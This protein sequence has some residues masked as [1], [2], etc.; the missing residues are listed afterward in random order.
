MPSTPDASRGVAGRLVALAGM[1]RQHGVPVGTSGVVD[2]ADVARTLGLADRERLRAGLASALLSRAADRPVFDQLFDVYFPRT[3]GDLTLTWAPDPSIGPRERARAVREELAV[4]LAENDA[5]ALDRLAARALDELGLLE[6]AATLG[7]WSAQQTLDILTPQ[8]AIVPALALARGRAGARSGPHGTGQGSGGTSPARF[9]DRVDRDEV[10]A[11]VAAFRRRVESESRRRN[12]EARGT[13]RIGRYA[14]RAPLDQ[15]DILLTGAA[16]VAEL[17]AVVGPLSRRL[18]TRLS[19][20]QR[21]AT[22]GQ[23]DIRR[24]LRAAMSTGGVPMRP[25]YVHR[26]R[27]RADL[28]VMSD[29]SSS[30]L[31]FS[32]F[33][34]LLMQALAG[35]FRRMRVIGFVNVCDEITDLVAGAAPGDDVRTEIARTARM[36]RFHGNSDYGTAFADVTE[37]YLEMLSPRST[38]L[39]LGDARSNGTDPGLDELR[40]IRDHA[41]HVAWL[42]P[43]PVERWGSGD[44]EAIRYAEV[45]DMHECRTIDQLR[46]FVSRQMPV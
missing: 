36:T 45:V 43:E 39:I 2:A 32:R 4:A 30:V 16:E 15:R 21:R 20:R 41:R 10:R 17:R 28:V 3:A 19:A 22:R 33:T 38:V 11:R 46:L 18:A 27:S 9:T 34:L 26:H 6:N 5:L 23:V 1:L 29:M 24:T 7:G 37:R 40:T 44:S 12:A 14:V 13:E 35:Q 25:A 31:G 42:N 8:T